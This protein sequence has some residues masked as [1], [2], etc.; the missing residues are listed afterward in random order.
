MSAAAR[1]QCRVCRVSETFAHA[2][3]L[4]KQVPTRATPRSPQSTGT[5]NTRARSF[6]TVTSVTSAEMP[7][8]TTLPA[9]TMSPAT[10]VTTT[11]TTTTPAKHFRLQ[12]LQSN[13]EARERVFNSTTCSGATSGGCAR[14]HPPRTTKNGTNT[15]PTQLSLSASLQLTHTLGG[16]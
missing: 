16:Y 11:L 9:F 15:K 5:C 3:A 4:A 12:R 10:A 13:I 8:P 1:L 7:A 6:L 2:R 14:A